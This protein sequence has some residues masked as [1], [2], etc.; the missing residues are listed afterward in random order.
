M[1]PQAKVQSQLVLVPFARPGLDLAGIGLS[2]RRRPIPPR[3]GQA[4]HHRLV[5]A[6][7]ELS[8]PVA[9]HAVAAHG[10]DHRVQ[11]ARVELRQ[12]ADVV[13]I[14]R[15]R[16]VQA[17]VRIFGKGHAIHVLGAAGRQVVA[18]SDE[19]KLVMVKSF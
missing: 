14:D 2:R 6:D 5:L 7:V 10:L 15:R 4:G 18:R 3:F 12:E 19:F 11:Y 8:E 9:L 1:G 13:V 17:K 16:Q